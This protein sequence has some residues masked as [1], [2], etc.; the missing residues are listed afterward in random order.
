MTNVPVFTVPVTTTNV[1]TTS[2]AKRPRS[3]SPVEHTQITE[4]PTLTLDQLKRQYGH[5]SVSNPIELLRSIL[6][7]FF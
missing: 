5:M 3:D 2:T 4:M 7:L 1:I 6:V